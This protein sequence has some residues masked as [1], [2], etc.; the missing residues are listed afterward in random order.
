MRIV[1]VG[2]GPAGLFFA[3]LMKKEDPKHEITVIDRNRP[4]HTFGFGVVF[5]DQ[6]LENVAEADPATYE[7]VTDR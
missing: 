6:A 5:S 2:A 3:I 1:S 7:K 4:D